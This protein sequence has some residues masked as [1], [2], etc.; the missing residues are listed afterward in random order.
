M[1][2]IGTMQQCAQLHTT[3]PCNVQA[4]SCCYYCLELL[5]LWLQR[6]TQR[7]TPDAQAHPQPQTNSLGYH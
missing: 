7:R 2:V 4:L 5:Q 3:S 6:R 1:V